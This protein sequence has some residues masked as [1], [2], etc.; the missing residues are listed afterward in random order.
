MSVSPKIKKQLLKALYEAYD[1]AASDFSSAC[2]R[3]C[4]VCCTHNVVATSLEAE[5]LLKCLEDA[6]RT[7]VIQAM[8]GTPTVRRLRPA[9]SINALAACCLRRIEP[10]EEESE[11]ERLPC[12]IR[13]K[14]GCYCYDARPLGC[15]CVWSEELCSPDGEA[16]MRP[17]LVT[18]NGVFQQIAEHLDIGGLYG[19]LSDLVIALGNRDIQSAYRSGWPLKA[20]LHLHCTV[21][22]PGFLV[23]PEH[24]HAVSRVL[25]RLWEKRVGDRSFRQAMLEVGTEAG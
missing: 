12:P 16:V 24:R 19:N 2:T 11:I 13:G 1:E 18:I 15:R 4:D 3:Q 10:P 9:L 17:L 22:S 7:D 25:S 6:G 21:R 14:D 8:E 20:T 23:P 5:V